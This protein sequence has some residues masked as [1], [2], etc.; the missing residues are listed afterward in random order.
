M[1]IANHLVHFL[2]NYKYNYYNYLY[3]KNNIIFNKEQILDKNN[4]DD[5]NNN[6]INLIKNKKINNLKNVNNNKKE[7]SVD[8]DNEINTSINK[9]QSDKENINWPHKNKIIN[10]T[11]IFDSND[12]KLLFNKKNG[13]GK[14]NKENNK[15]PNFDLIKNEVNKKASDTGNI[16]NRKENKTN[17][18]IK[19]S[20][21]VDENW[22]WGWPRGCPRP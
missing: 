21:F 14:N 3:E 15:S 1:I 10:N 11:E 22:S 13:E 18:I 16:N 12:V 4:I 6:K 20:G 8:Y 17:I 19:K 5:N 9:N 7:I 2:V